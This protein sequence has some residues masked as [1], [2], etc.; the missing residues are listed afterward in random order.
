M[1]F[2]I[3]G[4]EYDV[5]AGASKATL[6]TLYVMKTKYGIGVKQL[7]EMSRKFKTFKNPLDILDDPDAFNA[8][9]AMIW[10]ARV[11]AGEKITMDEACDFPLDQMVF[12]SPDDEAEDEAD[13]KA[14]AASV[15]ADE[16]PQVTETSETIPTT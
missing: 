10:L 9:R 13:P 7:V 2:T 4:R 11:H 6:Q 8:F 1:K 16:L 15:P 12:T 14:E 3:E 5:E